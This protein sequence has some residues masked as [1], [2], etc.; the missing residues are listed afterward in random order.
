MNSETG[1]PNFNSKQVELLLYLGSNLDREHFSLVRK[2]W[3]KH[4]SRQRKFTGIHISNVLSRLCEDVRP[5]SSENV[6]TI[7]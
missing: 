7:S 3:K 5:L 6:L 4:R 2:D 1:P